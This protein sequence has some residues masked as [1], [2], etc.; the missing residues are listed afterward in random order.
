MVIDLLGPS[1]EDLFTFCG[2]KFSVKTVIMLADQMVRPCRRAW[3]CSCA[4]ISVVRGMRSVAA[5]CCCRSVVKQ[6]A[7]PSH[8]DKALPCA[9]VFVT[10]AAVAG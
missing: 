7:A 1:L 9:L 8:C 4:G 3:Y 5:A 6:Q 10:I 2:R